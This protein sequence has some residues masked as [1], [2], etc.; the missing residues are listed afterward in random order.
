MKIIIS[1][2][3]LKLLL[4]NKKDIDEEELSSSDTSTKTSSYPEVG[5]WSTDLDRSG[6]ANQIDTK[7]RW[8]E[9]VGSKLTRGKANKLK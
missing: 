5:K 8:S 6:P 1:E 4:S 9:I 3:Q 2:K 7:S